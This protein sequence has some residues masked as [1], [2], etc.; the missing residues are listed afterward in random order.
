[1]ADKGPYRQESSIIFHAFKAASKGIKEENLMALVDKMGGS[2]YR[3][4]KVLKRG[5][6][7]KGVWSWDVEEHNGY[8][9]LLNVR[10]LAKVQQPSQTTPKRKK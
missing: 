9:K 10:S 2:P 3:I 6:D 4:L 1:M 7:S 5:H 8:L